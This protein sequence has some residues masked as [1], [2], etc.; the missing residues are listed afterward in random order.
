[1]PTAAK[2]AAMAAPV[3][4][5]EPPGLRSSAYGLRVW[6]NSEPPDGGAYFA[7]SNFF[8]AG[9]QEAYWGVNYARLRETKR[10][11]DPDGL[12][13]VHHGVGSEEWSRDGFTRTAGR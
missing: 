6:P 8:E 3:P 5:L 4:P 13:F 10:K 2:L 12:L 9:W 1:M 7:E 11:Y